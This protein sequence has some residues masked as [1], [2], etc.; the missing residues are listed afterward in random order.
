MDARYDLAG[1]M[2]RL[3]KF[4]RA[5]NL[6]NFHIAGNS[7]GGFFAGTYAARYSAEI[8]SLGLFDAGGVRSLQMSEVSKLRAKRENPLLL[9]DSNDFD[10]LM[11]LVFFQPP[12]F[13]YPLKY[14]F[15]RKALANRV[16]NEK[17]LKELEID[18]FSL[19]KEL[20]RITAPAL[21]LWGDKDKIIDISS[22]AVFEK[23]LKNHKTVII[24]DCGHAPMIEKARET[25][26]EYLAFI[27]SIGN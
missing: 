15:V 17:M 11:K 7:L 26:G 9:K 3:H 24:K 6:K 14:V 1:Q 18:F 2:E 12:F 10:R 25:A 20:P 4:I 8:V 5:L 19:E 27:K 21:I 22:A 16:F 23:G 13:P